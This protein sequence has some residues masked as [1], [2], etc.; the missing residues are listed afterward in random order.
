VIVRLD[1]EGI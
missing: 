1:Q